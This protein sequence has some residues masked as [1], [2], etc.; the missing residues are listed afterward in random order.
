MALSA[1]SSSE[2]AILGVE[3]LAIVISGFLGKDQGPQPILGKP[4]ALTSFT[5]S[6]PKM[7]SSPNAFEISEIQE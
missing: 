1:C 3:R 6:L 5:L 2:T 7:S 4:S